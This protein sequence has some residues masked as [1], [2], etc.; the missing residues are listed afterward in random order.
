MSIKNL[1]ADQLGYFSVQDIASTLIGVMA[2]AVLGYVIA[3]LARAKD[4]GAKEMAMTAAVMA[5]ASGLV[6]DSVPL[7]IALVAAVLLVRGATELTSRAALLRFTALAIGLGCGASASV[8][9]MAVGI[10]LALLLRWGTAER[11]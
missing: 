1:I 6:R 8:V 7:A 2:A 4:P 3:L 9:V 10:P 11:S 5:F